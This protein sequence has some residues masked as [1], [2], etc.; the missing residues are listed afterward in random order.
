[1][2]TSETSLE[3]K[4]EIKAEAAKLV[5][6]LDANRDEFVR[7]INERRVAETRRLV[8]AAAKEL[9]SELGS[10][11]ALSGAP[12]LSVDAVDNSETYSSSEDS[13]GNDSETSPSSGD[14]AGDVS[15]PSSSESEGASNHALYHGS[16][17]PRG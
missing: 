10:A 8:E 6:F 15:D 7:K 9:L 17:P 3:R 16:K 14:S 12:E 5:A 1:M 11:H 2:S 13:T 4:A